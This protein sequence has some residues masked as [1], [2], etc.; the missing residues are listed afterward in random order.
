MANIAD[1]IQSRARTVKRNKNISNIYILYLL[2]LF[3]SSIL[4][5]ATVLLAMQS[6]VATVFRMPTWASYLCTYGPTIAFVFVCL[7]LNSNKQIAIAIILSTGFA[8]LMLAVTVGTLVSVARDG[9]ITPDSLFLYVLIAAFAL[10]GILHPYEMSDLIWGLL[11][12]LCIPAGYLFLVIY[13][14]CNMHVTSWGTRETKSTLASGSKNIQADADNKY[15]GEAAEALRARLE[16]QPDS[17]CCGCITWC[18]M[19]NAIIL[20]ILQSLQKLDHERSTIDLERNCSEHVN[21]SLDNRSQSAIS[22]NNHN[23]MEWLNSNEFIPGTLKQ[24]SDKEIHFWKHMI[25]VYLNPNDKQTNT[26]TDEVI[27]AMTKLRNKSAFSFFFLNGLWLVIMT[28]LQEVKR[29]LNFKIENNFG[30]PIIVHPL[31]LLFLVVFAILLLLQIAAMVKHRYGTAL[32]VLAFLKLGSH[33]DNAEYIKMILTENVSRH[34]VS[35]V[36][37][38]SSLI[39]KPASDGDNN[40]FKPPL[41]DDKFIQQDYKRLYKR[42]R[43]GTVREYNN[44]ISDTRDRKVYDLQSEFRRIKPQLQKDYNTYRHTISQRRH[45]PRD[46]L[47]ESTSSFHRTNN[48]KYI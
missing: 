45:L 7:M 30:P 24:L 16:K 14:I 43:Q 11:Y 25:A 28:A 41:S 44:D 9:W 26:E 22:P 18:R 5:P 3:V 35:T 15:L 4:G 31:G 46:W 21:A 6:S 19:I 8:F 17:G 47:S 12:F 23:T 38:A 37:S 20:F 33:V 48:L 29:E 2:T 13:S 40:M 34:S 39:A 42:T 27:T 10:A 32:H 36:T 1:L